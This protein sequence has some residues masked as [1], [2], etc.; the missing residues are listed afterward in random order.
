MIQPSICSWCKPISTS[1]HSNGRGKM[2]STSKRPVLPPETEGDNSMVYPLSKEG[3]WKVVV[4]LKT[5]KPMEN[6]MF[7]WSN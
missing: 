4:L 5:T 1:T 6:I 7:W 2:P 3:Y